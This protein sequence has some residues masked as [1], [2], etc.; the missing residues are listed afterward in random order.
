MS[1][2]KIPEKIDRHRQ[3]SDRKGVLGLFEVFIRRFRTL[4]F[5]IVLMP[6][7]IM[8]L[9]VIALSLAPA[10]LITASLHHWLKSYSLVVYSLGLGVGLSVSFFVFGFS[11]LLITPLVNFLFP[12]KVKPWRGNWRSLETVPWYVHNALVYVVRYLFLDLVTPSP[13]CTMFYRLMGMKIGKGV[14]INTTN[15][16]DP[17]LIEIE[18]YVTIGGSVHM[19]AHYGQK[20]YLILAPVKIGRGA[21]IGLK[22]S[23]M[24]DV[25]I[26]AEATVKPHSVVLPKTRIA[27][28]E[29]FG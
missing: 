23:I 16:S 24:G 2:R 9:S 7:V 19:L 5:I 25:E 12:F 13:L 14:I 20:G 27:E 4:S 10:V 1:I 28:G 15:I 29:I 8:C 22:A 26:G 21:N 3:D 11:L 18:D 17:C 6:I